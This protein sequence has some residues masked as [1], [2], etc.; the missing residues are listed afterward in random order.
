MAKKQYT[1]TNKQIPYET[2]ISSALCRGQK[3][4]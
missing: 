2:H 4:S 3:I 1:Q